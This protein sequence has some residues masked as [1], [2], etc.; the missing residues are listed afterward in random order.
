MCVYLRIKFQDSSVIV[1]IFR[2]GD[3]GGVLKKK[4]T[5]PKKP[6]KVRVNITNVSEKPQ[7]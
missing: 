5:K 3:G 7:S 4:K 2:W 6:T 1:K